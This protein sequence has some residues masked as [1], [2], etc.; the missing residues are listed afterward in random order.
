MNI[1][2][3]CADQKKPYAGYLRQQDGRKVKFVADPDSAPRAE[4]CV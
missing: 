2:I 4:S 1:V 3:V